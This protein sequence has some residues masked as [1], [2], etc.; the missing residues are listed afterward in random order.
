[1]KGP[2]FS[3]QMR[4]NIRRTGGL[5]YGTRGIFWYTETFY[6]PKRRHLDSGMLSPVDLEKGQL[7]LQGVVY[8]ELR[9]TPSD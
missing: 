1:M 2:V 5:P 8:R 7:K 6:N 9:N 3:L 4:P